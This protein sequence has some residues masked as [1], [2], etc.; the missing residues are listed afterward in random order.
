MA[1]FAGAFAVL[2]GLITRWIGRHR[3]GVEKTEKT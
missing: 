1:V 2:G 3:A